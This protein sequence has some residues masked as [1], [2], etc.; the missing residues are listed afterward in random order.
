MFFFLGAGLDAEPVL[1]SL[2]IDLVVG[3][4]FLV[5]VGDQVLG[6]EILVF[7]LL[8]AASNACGCFDFS[9]DSGTNVAPHA[10]HVTGSSLPRS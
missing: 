4:D 1:A 3:R 7:F 2:K 6:R 8:V 9:T 5:L 10:M